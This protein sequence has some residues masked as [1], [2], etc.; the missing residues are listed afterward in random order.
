MRYVA[1]VQNKAADIRAR[2]HRRD[3]DAKEIEYTLE[4]GRSLAEEHRFC[5]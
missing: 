1:K 3:G 5:R 4:E 2:V